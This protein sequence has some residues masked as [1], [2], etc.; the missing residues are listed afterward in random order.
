[1]QGGQQGSAAPCTDSVIWN[2]VSFCSHVGSSGF[3]QSRGQTAGRSGGQKGCLSVVA[4]V[5]GLAVWRPLVGPDPKGSGDGRCAVTLPLLPL[6][7]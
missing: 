7:V 4:T 3:F 5:E 2:V 6:S 1:M